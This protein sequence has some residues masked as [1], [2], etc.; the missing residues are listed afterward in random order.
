MLFTDTIKQCGEVAGYLWQ[1]GWAER[2]GGNLVVN[3]TDETDNS[4]RQL[5]PL[6]APIETGVPV[7]SIANQ[8]FFCKASGCRMR[9][10][11]KLPMDNGCIIRITEDA[12]HYEIIACKPLQPTSELASHLL[13]HNYL[14]ATDSPHKASLHTHPTELIAL[15]HID[16]LLEGDR[17][18]QLLWDMI[19]ETRLFCPKGIGIQPYAE[20]GSDELAQGTLEL[21]QQHNAILWE[22]HGIIAVG[23]DIMDAFDTI[24]I[25]NKSAQIRC[26]LGAA[27]QECR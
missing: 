8:Y 16:S 27:L 9:D 22:K 23:K 21:L 19:P 11:A 17:M 14:V 5:K 7:P 15:S 24:D 20:P 26:A 18:T 10:L 13:I 4:L 25:L 6:S 3:I 1:K 12:E 2:N